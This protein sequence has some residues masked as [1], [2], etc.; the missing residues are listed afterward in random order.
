VSQSYKEAIA[1]LRS[2]AVCSQGLNCVKRPR[3]F[4]QVLAYET[5]VISVVFTFI[6]YDYVKFIS[7]CLLVFPIEVCNINDLVASLLAEGWEFIGIGRFTQLPQGRLHIS[8]VR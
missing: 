6:T 1:S 7:S 8:I 4:K 5:A 2:E 3:K